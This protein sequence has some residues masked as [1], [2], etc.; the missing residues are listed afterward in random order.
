MPR[1]G[2]ATVTSTSLAGQFPDQGP[3]PRSA[4][5]FAET[6]IGA[7][8]ASANPPLEAIRNVMANPLGPDDA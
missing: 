2:T 3:N 6:I 1:A 7:G 8:L 5:A 4:Q